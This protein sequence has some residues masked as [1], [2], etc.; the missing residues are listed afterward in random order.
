MNRIVCIIFRISDTTEIIIKFKY[1]GKIMKL[2][3]KIC[4]ISLLVMP[5]LMVACGG[6]ND[7][8]ASAVDKSSDESQIAYSAISGTAFG[9]STLNNANVI[10]KC[11]DG[12]G[13]KEV[14]KVDTQGKWQGEIDGS[15]FPCRLEVK[16]NEQSYHSYISQVGSVNIN[17]L[18]DL[19]IAYA[20]TQIPTTWYQSGIIDEEK[21]KSA[22][23]A[24]VA[25]LIKKEY[26]LDN[27][28]DVFNAEIKANNPIHLA[29]QAL[30]AAIQGSNTIQ[31]YNALLT[32]V[33]DGNLSQLP[34]KMKNLNIDI[35][36]D[37]LPGV[38][39][40]STAKFNNKACTQVENTTELYSHC[41]KDVIG[42]FKNLSLVS[43]VGV[44]DSGI[45]TKPCGVYKHGENLTIQTGG[46]SITAQFTSQ[47]FDQIFYQNDENQIIVSASPSRNGFNTARLVFRD[48]KLFTATFEGY[49]NNDSS[50]ENQELICI[51]N[52][53]TL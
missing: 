30:F 13:F 11:K 40:F 37:D 38:I 8:N 52:S 7:N 2:N 42:D 24:L 19:A 23:S 31:D 53:N 34:E 17:P 20:S 4:K 16:A 5:V 12:I 26:V 29:I 28:T 45:L 15:K 10:A 50:G 47:S 14:V 25:E 22:N 41:N 39:D 49:L 18:T 43:I 32:L 3:K 21:L 48:H 6:G 36:L 51:V 46:K 44:S 1:Q 9:F 35:N 33:K 27:K